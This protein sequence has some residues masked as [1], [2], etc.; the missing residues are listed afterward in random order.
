MFMGTWVDDDMTTGRYYYAS[1]QR[2][3]GGFKNGKRHGKGKLQKL[4]GSLDI[5]IYDD[6]Q[7][8]GPGIRWSP[9]RSTTW[10]LKENGTIKNKSN[11]AEAVS[12]DYG[13]QADSAAVSSSNAAVVVPSDDGGQ[14]NDA[15]EMQNGE[16]A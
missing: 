15:S 1:G 16:L 5:F 8:R 2:F 3:E 12:F 10:I 4:D 6:D 11:I 9:D 14:G 7:R 13:M